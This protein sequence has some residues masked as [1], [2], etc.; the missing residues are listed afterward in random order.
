MVWRH[1]HPEDQS[2]LA[3]KNFTETFVKNALILV[4]VN[5]G[6]IIED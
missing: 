6:I 4:A 5:S 2:K 1:P 3:V